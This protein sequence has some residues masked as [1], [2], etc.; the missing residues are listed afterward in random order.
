MLHVGCRENTIDTLNKQAG[1]TTEYNDCPWV[2]VLS[3]SYV[4]YLIYIVFLMTDQPTNDYNTKNVETFPLP[5]L[6]DARAI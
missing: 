5:W 4:R 6:G 3:I 1:L 2:T